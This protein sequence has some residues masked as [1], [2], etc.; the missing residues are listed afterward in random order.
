MAIDRQGFSIRATYS[1]G[2]REIFNVRPPP[3]G[4]EYAFLLVL[5]YSL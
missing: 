5:A 3:E 1:W 2:S 4:G